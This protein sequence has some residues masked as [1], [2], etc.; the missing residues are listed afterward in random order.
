MLTH[1]T[2]KSLEKQRLKA[3]AIMTKSKLAL[4]ARTQVRTQAAEAE[5]LLLYAPVRSSKSSD[6]KALERDV[7]DVFKDLADATTDL[8][9]V[10][11]T[12]PHARDLKGTAKKV[13]SRSK[14]GLKAFTS[15]F[16]FVHKRIHV[17]RHDE[18]IQFILDVPSDP[19]SKASSSSTEVDITDLVLVVLGACRSHGSHDNIGE[20]VQQLMVAMHG[21]MKQVLEHIPMK[22]RKQWKA[23]L[24]VD[25]V[26]EQGEELAQHA[27]NMVFGFEATPVDFHYGF[28][29]IASF[30]DSPT[31][32][33]HEDVRTD[34]HDDEKPSGK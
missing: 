19:S 17:K 2:K 33:A 31:V 8:R 10:L 20:D 18:G 23:E 13:M 15:T 1:A 27:R 29:A 6:D 25:A 30:D 34:G 32:D 16:K 21:V 7:K 4:R 14:V 9:S 12:F 11:T 24:L 3:N 5:A 22:H 28:D 26:H